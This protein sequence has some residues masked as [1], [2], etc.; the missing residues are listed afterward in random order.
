MGSNLPEKKRYALGD[1][2]GAELWIFRGDITRF[3]GELT[4][5]W[6]SGSCV[7]ASSKL[8]GRLIRPSLACH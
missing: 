3:T 2:G 7:E 1:N 6:T 5:S 4:A 8:E